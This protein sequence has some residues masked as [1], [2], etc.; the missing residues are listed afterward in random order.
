VKLAKK[1][2]FR[3]ACFIAVESI[4]SKFMPVGVPVELATDVT[5][6]RSS[7]PNNLNVK[8]S[9][10]SRGCLCNLPP[11]DLRAS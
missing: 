1:F 3:P 7:P 8:S 10:T 5:A 9:D 4:V 6:R 2:S 11:Y